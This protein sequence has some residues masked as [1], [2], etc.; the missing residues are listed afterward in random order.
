M[1]MWNFYGI[2]PPGFPRQGYGFGDLCAWTD[3]DQE[4]FDIFRREVDE[5]LVYAKYNLVKTRLLKR[6]I[7]RVSGD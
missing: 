2:R 1:S 7:W 4:D 3:K 6:R 5:F